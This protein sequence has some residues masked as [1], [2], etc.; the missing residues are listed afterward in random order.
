GWIGCNAKHTIFVDHTLKF[1]TGDQAAANVVVP[2][3]L[4]ILLYIYGRVTSH[5]DYSSYTEISAIIQILKGVVSPA[6]APCRSA[7]RGVL[8]RLAARSEKHR[9]VL[10]PARDR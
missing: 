5:Q 2:D 4:P 6:L 7:A 1:T 8:P 9:R 3:T 10:P